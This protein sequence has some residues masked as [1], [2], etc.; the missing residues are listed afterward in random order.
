MIFDVPTGDSMLKGL[1]LK[2]IAEPLGVL[3]RYTREGIE[4]EKTIRMFIDWCGTGRGRMF[5]GQM[6]WSVYTIDAMVREEV[7]SRIARW[8]GKAGSNGESQGII[9]Q[10][11]WKDCSRRGAREKLVKILYGCWEDDGR[12]NFSRQPLGSWRTERHKNVRFEEW[13]E[14]KWGRDLGK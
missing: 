9:L 7:G 11:D 10:R 3:R 1:A 4:N 12:S 6:L 8:V 2:R 14:D 13:E 5:C